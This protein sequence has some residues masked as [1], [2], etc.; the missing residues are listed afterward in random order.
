M[1]EALAKI[2]D[3]NFEYIY[4]ARI[5]SSEFMFVSYMSSSNGLFWVCVERGEKDLWKIEDLEYFSA[6]FIILK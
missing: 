4:V 1:A 3:S 5:P 6:V 2:S